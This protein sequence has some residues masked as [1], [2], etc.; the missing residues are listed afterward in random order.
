M[1]G[2]LSTCPGGG[3]WM[4]FIPRWQ[5][6]L[7]KA[8]THAGSHSLTLPVVIP[9]ERARYVV[10][11][12]QG[13]HPI[14]QDL[15]HL[16]HLSLFASE[17]LRVMLINQTVAMFLPQNW[18]F[19]TNFYHKNACSVCII[20]HWHCTDSLEHANCNRTSKLMAVDF[21]P[22]LFLH[23]TPSARSTDLY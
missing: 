17:N 21:F 5:G 12:W 6:D 16:P 9:R 10:I 1:W 13:G 14:G 20:L 7:H 8:D 11:G 19:T 18:V 15:I 2:R 22:L 3:R 23:Y 4:A